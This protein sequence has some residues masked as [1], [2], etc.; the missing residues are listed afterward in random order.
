MGKD[1]S[2]DLQQTIALL[3]RTPAVL[4]ALLR[5]MPD[6]WTMSNEGEDTWSAFDVVGHLIMADRTNWIPRA[7]MIL[8][9]GD[10]RP[11]PA[12]DRTKHRKEIEGKSLSE[13]L[14]TFARV[15]SE[16]LDQLRA[17]DLKPADL[18]RRGQHPALGTVTLGHLLATWATHDLTHLHQIVRVMGY[19]YRDEVG[20]FR[21]FL[22]VLKCSGHSEAA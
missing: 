18:E 21:K 20:T 8:E 16:S 1:M 4:D 9:S 17:L 10:S 22:G 3:T 7:Q 6:A 15:R 11:F 13:L 14:D 5:D 2:Q 19:Q 12:F